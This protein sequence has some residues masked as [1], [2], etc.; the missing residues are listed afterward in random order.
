MVVLRLS[1]LP[2]FVRLKQ[3]VASQTAQIDLLHKK[4]VQEQQW[5]NQRGVGYVDNRHTKCRKEAW[6]SLNFTVD[7]RGYEGKGSNMNNKI[8]KK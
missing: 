7:I 5:K 2:Q 8:S 3:L 4:Y 1:P 6:S